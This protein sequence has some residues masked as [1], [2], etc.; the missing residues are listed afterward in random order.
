MVHIMNRGDYQRAR[1]DAQGWMAAALSMHAMMMMKTQGKEV[2][3]RG[4]HRRD[5]ARRPAWHDEQDAGINALLVSAVIHGFHRIQ[6]RLARDS[7]L[8]LYFR[9][10]CT[11]GT[12]WSYYG[13]EL[14]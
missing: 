10:S 13:C 12:W 6:N 11:A 7:C 5:R 2:I 8:D 4:I 3:I 1:Q 14:P 9:C